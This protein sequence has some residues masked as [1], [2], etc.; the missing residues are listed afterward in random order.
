MNFEEES[1]MHGGLELV[2]EEGYTLDL[3]RT[4]RTAQDA[5]GGSRETSERLPD[6]DVRTNVIE[7][8]ANRK[9]GKSKEMTSDSTRA[10]KGKTHRDT[11]Q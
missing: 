10:G 5:G 11:R 2:R 3:N 1:S 9:A 4:K 6:A 7:I 8:D